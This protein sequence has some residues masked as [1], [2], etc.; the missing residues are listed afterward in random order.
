MQSVTALAGRLA[1]L[2]ASILIVGTATAADVAIPGSGL[3]MISPAMHS[4]LQQPIVTPD[5]GRR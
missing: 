2:L 5:T 4:A 3:A 1:A